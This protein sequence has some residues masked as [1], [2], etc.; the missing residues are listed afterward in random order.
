MGQPI[1]T[2]PL[3]IAAINMTVVF[4]VL[5]GLCLIIQLIQY[6]DPTKKRQAQA[7]INDSQVDLAATTEPAVK[8]QAE[9]DELIIVFT[10]ALAAYSKNE[11][12]IVSIRPV[13]GRN[14]SQTARMEAINGR[15]RMF[16]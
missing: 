14:W 11:L 4:A 12:R 3:I 5:Y 7:E 6:I 16:Q 2:N 10:A 15:N 1:T 9:F 13:G 8:P